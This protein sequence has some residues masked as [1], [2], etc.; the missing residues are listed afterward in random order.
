MAEPE[1]QLLLRPVERI[2]HVPGIESPTLLEYPLALISAPRRLAP[3]PAT[4]S[5]TSAQNAPSLAPRGTLLAT[6]IRCGLAR[7][8]SAARS[9]DGSSIDTSAWGRFWRTEKASASAY[10]RGP[11]DIRTRGAVIPAPICA[12]KV[13]AG[14]GAGKCPKDLVSLTLSQAGCSQPVKARTQKKGPPVL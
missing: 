6:I 1:E 11:M 3:W 10:M 7:R 14:P 8:A 4:G 2:D 13:R 12:N 5:V 9:S